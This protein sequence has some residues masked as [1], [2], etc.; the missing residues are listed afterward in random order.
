MVREGIESLEILLELVVE[1]TI[2]LIIKRYPFSTILHPYNVRFQKPMF[3]IIYIP[4]SEDHRDAGTFQ[5]CDS[6]NDFRERDD[7]WVTFSGTFVLKLGKRF[8]FRHLAALRCLFSHF[9]R[10]I[11][12]F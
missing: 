7:G 4:F 5:L 10:F 11:L 2:K 9:L 8:S 12:Y 6:E 3:F 1:N